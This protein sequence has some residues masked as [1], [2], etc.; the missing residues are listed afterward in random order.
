ME[1]AFWADNF[2]MK[3]Y[4]DFTVKQLAPCADDDLDCDYSD[5]SRVRSFGENECSAEKR[6]ELGSLLVRKYGKK[7]GEVFIENIKC[8][9]T[10]ELYI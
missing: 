10:E 8:I 3:K 9:D 2:P 7:L 4:M 1:L 5:F 6:E